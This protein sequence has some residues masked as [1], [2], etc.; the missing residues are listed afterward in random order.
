MGKNFFYVLVSQ[1]I[2]GLYRIIAHYRSTAMDKLK[3]QQSLI[4]MTIPP[5]VFAGGVNHINVLYQEL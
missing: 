2:T 4:E 3:P 1:N 5:P